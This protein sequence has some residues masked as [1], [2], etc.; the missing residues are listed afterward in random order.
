[1]KMLAATA[2]VLAFVALPAFAQVAKMGELADADGDGAYS[3]DEVKVAYPDLTELAFNEIDVDKDGKLSAEEV[4]AAYA[5][6][7]LAQ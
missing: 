6:N 4:E 5:A 3:M 2:A 1:M 7:V